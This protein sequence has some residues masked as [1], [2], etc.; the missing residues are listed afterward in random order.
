M[1]VNARTAENPAALVMQITASREAA[2][3]AIRD[4]VQ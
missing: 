1:G 2:D 3:M 4:R